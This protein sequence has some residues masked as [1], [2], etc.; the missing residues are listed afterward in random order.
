MSVIDMRSTPLAAGVMDREPIVNDFS[1]VAAT[2]NGSGS[3]TANTMLIRALFRMGIPV[4][5]KNLFPSNI[6]GLPTWYTIR[7]SKD[8]YIARRE[9]TEILVAFNQ[10]TAVEDLTGLPPGGVCVY[11]SEWNF[12]QNRDDVVYY[13][14]PV[15]EF[16]KASGAEARLRDYIANMVYVGALAALLGIDLDEIKAALNKH[17]NNRPKPV[18][19]NYGVVEAAAD[20]MRE[21][22]PKQDPYRVER[23]DLTKG[24]ILIDGNTASALGALFNGVTVAAWYPIT[25]ATSLADALT[26][27]APRLRRTEDGKPTYAI[28][29][30][31]DELAAIGMVLGA[32]WAGARAMTSTSGPGIS[33]MSEFAGLGYFAEIPGVIWD[34]QRM[35]PSTGLPTRVSQGDILA[36]YV[37]GHGDTRHVVLLPGSV[38]ECFEFAGTAF[39]L[40]EQLQTPVFVL[41]DLDLGM[42]LWM[43]S[44]FEY[45]EEPM[46]RG[47]VL[48]A[49]DIERMGGFARYRDDDGTGVG[50]R[51]LPGTDHPLAAYFTRGTGHNEFA[52][53]SERPDDWLHNLDRLARKH[54]YAR[55]LVPKPVIDEREGA[56]IGII[57]AGTVD[58]AVAEARDRLRKMEIETSYLR[59]RALPIGEEL[60]DFVVRHDRVY[61]VELNHDGQLC[62]ILRMELPEY[63][64]R[65][66]S[67]AYCDGLPLT[68]RWVTEAI[69]EQ[70]Q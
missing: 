57:A 67:L 41:S 42:N 1:I 35:G 51:T 22:L 58:P 12:E 62:Q 32:G 64:T 70:E 9:G 6:S 52:V 56:E 39:N 31:E 16:V 61:V 40:A 28:V 68:A 65:F 15:K 13:P 27:Y 18:N 60:H 54:D 59:L 10:K 47:K 49:E 43:T 33:L 50:P 19:L 4:N 7:V 3:Q 25:P 46:Q 69:T 26:E 8:G 14:V 20:W 11:P 66:V 30:A 37:L 63:A 5:G 24:Q 38:A 17:F 36:A 48:A 44:P 2:V 45:P 55:T 34:V 21:N 53:Y 23:M 29:Q